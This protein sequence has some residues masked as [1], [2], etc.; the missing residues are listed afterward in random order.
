MHCT[1][2]ALPNNSFDLL[3]DMDD[4]V[5]LPQRVYGVVHTH[6][7]AFTFVMVLHNKLGDMIPLWQNNREFDIIWEIIG[8]SQPH[9]RT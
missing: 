7:M 2:R 3:A 1:F 8:V 4:K 6:L 5:L 9:V